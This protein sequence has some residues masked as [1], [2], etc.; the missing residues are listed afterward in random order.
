MLTYATASP[1]QARPDSALARALGIPQL[2]LIVSDLHL[3]VGQDRH[4]LRY[5]P[6]EN[7]LLADDFRRLLEHHAPAHRDSSLLVLNGD[8]F[9]FLRI[10]ETPRTAEELQAWSDALGAL[11][12]PRPVNELAVSGHEVRYGLR[13]QDYKCVWKLLRIAEGHPRFF[14]ALR[15]WVSSG[16]TIVVVKGNHDL[17]LHWPLVQRQLRDLIAGPGEAALAARVLFC[18]TGFSIA[19]L[20]VEH[21]H[22][23]ERTTA[24]R[25]EAELPGGTEINYPPGSLVN[26]YLV[27]KIEGMEPFLDNQK[28]LSMLMRNLARR[29]PVKLLL[30]AWRSIPI[31]ARAL[32][33]F[34]FREAF[35]FAFFFA[36]FLLPVLVGVVV[37]LYFLVP[38]FAELVRGIP[39]TVRAVAGVVGVFMPYLAGALH[40]LLRK[41][42]TRH[43]EDE[44]AEGIYGVLGTLEDRERYAA[45][46]G[47]VGHTHVADAQFL[48][49]LGAVEAWYLNSGTWTPNWLEGRPDLTGRV[50]RSFLRFRLKG[51]GYAHECLEW[52]GQ[53]PPD[54]PA[55]ILEPLKS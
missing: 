8:T 12:V 25:G 4:T 31:L 21:G 18:E 51:A 33:R 38:P 13:T 5:S 2:V 19:N 40:D 32:R 17:E 10:V 47:V 6:R 42:R 23:F 20:Y 39:A 53:G 46:Y 36:A 1:S 35:A 54:A 26:R 3:G 29:H 9:D 49:P 27:N 15:Y 37:L 48:P 43:G 22:R 28:P 50:I 16:G 24:V 52:R 7:F 34:W 44:F 45:V 30:L 11:G 41:P 14:Q 55:V